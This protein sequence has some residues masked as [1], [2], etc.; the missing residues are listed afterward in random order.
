MPRGQDLPEAQAVRLP[1]ATGRRRGLDRDGLLGPRGQGLGRAVLA[2]ARRQVPR[3]DPDVRGHAGVPRPRRDGEPAQGP[4]G[5]RLHVPQDGREHQP[6]EGRRGRPHLPQGPGRR[7]VGPVRPQRLRPAPPPVHRHP[8]HGQGAEGPAGVRG[9]RARDRRL[10]DPDRHR[11]LR[12]LRHRGRDQAG[13]GARPLQPGVARGH[14]A[15]AVHRPVRAP[16]ELLQD[17]DPDRG[18]H[19]PEGGLQGPLR[20]EGHRDLPPRPR[21]LGRAP[22]DEEDRR[23]RDGARHRHGD[24]HGG[25]ARS[26]SSRASTARRPPRTSS[27]WS[28]TTSTTPGTTSS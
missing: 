26:R 16:E 12:P 15:L 3:Q 14:G 27:P 21:H 11:P 9:D 25:Q 1:R 22:R 20:E 10:G 18:G 5:A 6:A 23:P 13:A 17:A 4:D 8:D 24:A 19:L 2:D 7:P 28:T